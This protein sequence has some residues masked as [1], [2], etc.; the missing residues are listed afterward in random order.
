M[1]MKILED[2]LTLRRPKKTKETLAPLHKSPWEG[3]Q[4]IRGIRN[5]N[6]LVKSLACGA[7]SKKRKKQNKNKIKEKNKNPR[8]TGRPNQV[9][10]EGYK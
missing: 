5:P 6:A 2:K 10:Q 3:C 7:K 9:T 1:K 8:S 4:V